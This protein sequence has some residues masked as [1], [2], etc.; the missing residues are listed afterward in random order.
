MEKV[1]APARQPA[2]PAGGLSLIFRALLDRL[3]RL[4]KRS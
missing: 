2:K 4:F 1:A 3:K